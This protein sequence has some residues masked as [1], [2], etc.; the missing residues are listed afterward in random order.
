MKTQSANRAV[1]IALC[2]QL[3]WTSHPMIEPVGKLLMF[4]YMIEPP[5]Y[6]WLNTASELFCP[7]SLI[8]LTAP[9]WF[10]EFEVFFTLATNNFPSNNYIMIDLQTVTFVSLST[11]S[12]PFMQTVDTLE[13]YLNSMFFQVVVWNHYS[14]LMTTNTQLFK[15]G[16]CTQ[17]R[18][19]L[20]NCVLLMQF[21]LHL[22]QQTGN[23][24][25]SMASLP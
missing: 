22:M 2:E 19:N 21:G 7:T 5:Y 13:L 23:N 15:S 14:S 18:R 6:E 25:L 3:C 24:P 10:N 16:K 11:Q 20:Q 1:P 17:Q 8:V 4:F 12:F 9:H